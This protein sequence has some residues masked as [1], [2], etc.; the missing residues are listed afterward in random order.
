[1]VFH[2]ANDEILIDAHPH[3][4]TNKLPKL[5]AAIRETILSAGGEIHFNTKVTDL[6]IE[7]NII[8]GVITEGGDR[9]LKAVILATGHSAR[10]IFHLLYKK[11]IAIESNLLRWVLE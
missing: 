10:D 3:I 1:M 6:I 2:G 11:R 5:I 9:V 7:N 8:S 4:G